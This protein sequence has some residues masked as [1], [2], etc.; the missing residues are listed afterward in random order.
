MESSKSPKQP[1][2][3]IHPHEESRSRSPGSPPETRRSKRS[4]GS[5]GNT[6]VEIR[7][8]A[9][10]AGSIEAGVNI[11]LKPNYNKSFHKFH[12]SPTSER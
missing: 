9:M 5:R 8:N 6:K 3:G 2:R 4:G 1:G 7:L 11:T 12:F 10:L